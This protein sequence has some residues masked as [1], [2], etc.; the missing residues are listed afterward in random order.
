[1]PARSRRFFCPVLN[2]M[3]GISLV[4]TLMSIVVVS[5]GLLGL[6]ALQ[7]RATNAELESYQ[8]GQAL[9]LLHDM[10]NRIENNPNNAHNYLTG[11]TPVGTG[12]ESANCT[13][14]Q[15]RAAIDLCE[16]STLLQGASEHR[17]SQEIGVMVDA[18]GCI[19]RTSTERRYRIAVVWQGAGNAT[20]PTN[21]DCGEGLYDSEESRRAVTSTVLIPDLAGL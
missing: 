8:R 12:V 15:D 13:A 2:R 11:D 14:L 18:R 4:E 7:G 10:V 9:I 17:G 1:M 16:W 6:A 5:F 20:A 3:S 21:T 19:E